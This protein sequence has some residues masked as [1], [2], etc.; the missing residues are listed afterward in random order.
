[1][2]SSSALPSCQISETKSISVH[3][4][5]ASLKLADIRE[6]HTSRQQAGKPYALRVPETQ[7]LLKFKLTDEHQLTFPE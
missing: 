5:N 6:F 4:Q 1:M 7:I 3:W 2:M